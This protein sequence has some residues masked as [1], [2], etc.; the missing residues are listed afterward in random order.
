VSS[1]RSAWTATLRWLAILVPLVDVGL[2]L[3][4][5]LDVR[6][7]VLVGVALEAVLVIVVVAEFRAFRRSYRA[8]RADGRARA[9]AAGAGLRAV[10][11]PVVVALAVAEIGLW[12]S[13]WWAVRSRRD[14]GPG[15]VAISYSDRFTV[16]LWAVCCL[17]GLELAVVH[18]VTARWPVVRWTLFALGI[19]ALVWFVSFGLSL[20]QRPHVLADGELVLRFGWFRELRVPLQG[21]AVVRTGA[22]TGHR[23][24]LVLDGTDLAMSVM[25]DT[26]VELRFDPP[27]EAEVAGGCREVA[28]IAL[29]AD[30]PRAVAALLRARAVSSGG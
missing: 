15:E 30:D 3:T 26:N 13:L 6:T 21:L 28:R 19:Y 14:V 8:A 9:E 18:V 11:P 5:V 4:G 16:M 27:V 25:G 20:R 7:G 22:V 12:R 1:P 23:R 17:G 10:W 29:Y 24:N 2:V